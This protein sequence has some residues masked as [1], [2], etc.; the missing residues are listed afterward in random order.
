MVVPVF[1]LHVLN[2]Q[3]GFS[4]STSIKFTLEAHLRHWLS[5]SH[6]EYQCT[7]GYQEPTN[8]VSTST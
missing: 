2:G 4:W 7:E 8:D 6:T 5:I 3:I 1:A